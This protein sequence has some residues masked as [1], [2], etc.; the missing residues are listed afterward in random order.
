MKI[1]PPGAKEL[2][3]TKESQ[4]MFS[5]ISPPLLTPAA[6]DRCDIQGG[7]GVPSNRSRSCGK[8]LGDSTITCI[9]STNGSRE[10]K[11]PHKIA[12]EDVSF[13]K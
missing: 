9:T 11:K 3:E 7:K 4:H 12:L 5:V 1:N 2:F 6:E 10:E 13:K 8:E